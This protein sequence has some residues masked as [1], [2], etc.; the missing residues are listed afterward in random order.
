[1]TI[2]SITSSVELFPVIPR[3]TDQSSE[4]LPSLSK[5]ELPAEGTALC[6]HHDLILVATENRSIVGSELAYPIWWLPSIP[7]CG[8]MKCEWEQ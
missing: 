2:S 6:I 1:M 8:H 7:E 4:C 5:I 3:Q